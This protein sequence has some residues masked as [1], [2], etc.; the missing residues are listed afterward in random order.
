M[1]VLWWIIDQDFIRHPLPP[2]ELSWFVIGG[3]L[4]WTVTIV[5]SLYNLG[6]RRNLV[7]FFYFSRLFEMIFSWGSDVEFCCLLLA[8]N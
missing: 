1:R 5:L 3:L 4:R 6:D 2:R 8:K 7:T